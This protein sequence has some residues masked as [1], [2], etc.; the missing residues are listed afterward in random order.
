MHG[1]SKYGL[2]TEFQLLKK[3]S[4]LCPAK[5]VTGTLKWSVVHQQWVGCFTCMKIAYWTLFYAKASFIAQLVQS[6]TIIIFSS[7]FIQMDM[8]TQNIG[9]WRTAQKVPKG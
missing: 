9:E 8:A 1:R 3:S 6:Y 4:Y 2:K 5:W 7:Q